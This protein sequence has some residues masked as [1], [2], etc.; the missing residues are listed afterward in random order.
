MYVI[1]N[2]GDIQSS[3]YLEVTLGTNRKQ[4]YKTGDLLKQVKFK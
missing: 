3:L 2:T 1:I 4:P